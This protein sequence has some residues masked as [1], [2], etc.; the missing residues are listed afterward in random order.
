[1]KDTQ[2]YDVLFTFTEN[3]RS[4]M[5]YNAMVEATDVNN[6]VMEATLVLVGIYGTIDMCDMFVLHID[7]VRVDSVTLVDEPK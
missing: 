6:A 7:D 4:G 5:T 2:T 1:M 3:G